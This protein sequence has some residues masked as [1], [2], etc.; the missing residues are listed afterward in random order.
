MQHR[1]EKINFDKNCNQTINKDIIQTGASPK[2]RCTCGATKDENQRV[3]CV[4]GNNNALQQNR[5]FNAP[6]MQQS[7]DQSSQPSNTNAV[8]TVTNIKVL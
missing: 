8:A 2:I 3:R 1:L 5:S 6:E 4:C 7:V